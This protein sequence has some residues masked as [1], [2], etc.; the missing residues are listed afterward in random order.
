MATASQDGTVR[1]WDCID[2]NNQP[3]ELKDHQSWALSN[4]FSL[5]NKRLISTSKD[6]DRIIVW[7]IK[8]DYLANDLRELI[9][10]NMTQDEWNIYVAED[11]DY[12][13]TLVNIN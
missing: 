10:R 2:L 4:K 8:A 13:K 7:P 3:I 9:N 6:K 12:E 11:I 5:D 1:L